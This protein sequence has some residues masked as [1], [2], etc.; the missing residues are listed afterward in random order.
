[1]I[2]SR[3]TAEAQTIIPEAVR[4]AL[5]LREGDEL[6]YEIDGDRVVVRRFAAVDPFATFTEWTSEADCRAYA[7]FSPGTIA[8]VPFPTPIGTP[9]SIA[10]RLS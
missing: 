9:V 1:M 7:D 2:H 6:V 3:I 4:T 10:P 8:R 5:G